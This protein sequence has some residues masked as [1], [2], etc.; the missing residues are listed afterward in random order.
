[1]FTNI[2]RPHFLGE[3]FISRYPFSKN[4]TNTDSMTLNNLER[5]FCSHCLYLCTFH[6]N[7]CLKRSGRFIKQGQT[8]IYYFNN[9]RSV[10]NDNYTENGTV[11]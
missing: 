3:N 8:G 5:E 6:V 11:F 1:M 7:R 10:G 9:V 4:C 2:S